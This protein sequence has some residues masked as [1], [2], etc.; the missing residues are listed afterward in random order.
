MT[1]PLLFESGLADLSLSHQQKVVAMP[2]LFCGE[3]GMNTTDLAKKE[4]VG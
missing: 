1:P 4:V 3:I 2:P